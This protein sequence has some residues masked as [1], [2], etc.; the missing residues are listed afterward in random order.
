M[1]RFEDFSAQQIRMPVVST[2]AAGSLV[3]LSLTPASVAPIVAAKQTFTVAGLK[4]GDSVA[5]LSN[6]ITNA[7]ALVQA[8]VSAADTLRCMF[9]NPTAGALTPTAGTYTFLVIK[10]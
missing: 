6:P 9:V 10:S 8:E 2:P 3:S 4:L 1:S 5:I 7:V